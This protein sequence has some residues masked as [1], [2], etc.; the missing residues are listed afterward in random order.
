MCNAIVYAD[1]ASSNHNRKREYMKMLF[2]LPRQEIHLSV[3]RNLASGLTSLSTS[4]SLVEQSTS[5]SCC[6]DRF[7]RPL[8]EAMEIR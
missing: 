3:N 2:L 8:H 6:L 5:S 7:A 4:A 1:G